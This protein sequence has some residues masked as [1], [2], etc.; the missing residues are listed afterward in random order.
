MSGYPLPVALPDRSAPPFIAFE[1]DVEEFP[2][3][4]HECLLLLWFETSVIGRLANG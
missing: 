3:V 4:G 2:D 1:N